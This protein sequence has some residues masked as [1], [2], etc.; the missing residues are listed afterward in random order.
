MIGRLNDCCSTC[1]CGVVVCIDTWPPN[2]CVHGDA[3]C[4]DCYPGLC[5]DCAEDMARGAA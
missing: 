5:L 2:A 3:V 1:A 4:G